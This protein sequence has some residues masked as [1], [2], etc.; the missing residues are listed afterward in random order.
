MMRFEH[1]SLLLRKTN[2]CIVLRDTD[3]LEERMLIMV[4]ISDNKYRRGSIVSADHF[5]QNCENY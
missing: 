1:L 4:K 2:C 3:C 5:D